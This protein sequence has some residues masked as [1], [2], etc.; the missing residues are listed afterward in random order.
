MLLKR[1]EWVCQVYKN[2]FI[3]LKQNMRRFE[4]KDND[5][6]P[7]GGNSASHSSSKGPSIGGSDAVKVLKASQLNIKMDMEGN[8]EYPI[9]VTGTLKIFNL[10]IVDNTRSAFHSSSN[11][12][13][14]GFKSVREHASLY[15][16]GQRAEYTCE[17]LDDGSKPMFK[18]TCS[19]DM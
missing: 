3:S 6:I 1:A 8:I 11:I 7:T 4:Y 14:I 9:Q 12:F 18:V 13:P 5:G 2:H 15:A 10:G 16:I 17:I 19:E